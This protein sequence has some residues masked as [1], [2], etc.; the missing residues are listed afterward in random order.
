MLLYDSVTQPL[1]S[2]SLDIRH[3]LSED[4]GSTTLFMMG[5]AEMTGKAYF[6]EKGAN[7]QTYRLTIASDYQLWGMGNWMEESEM[8]LLL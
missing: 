2:N 7:E 5:G 1:S 6:M 3:R 4:I 8:T